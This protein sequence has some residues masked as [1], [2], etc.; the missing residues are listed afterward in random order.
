MYCSA[1]SYSDP[2]I[3]KL[4]PAESEKLYVED[5]IRL[6]R[7]FLASS[8]NRKACLARQSS[9]EATHL[10]VGQNS[11]CSRQA[12]YLAFQGT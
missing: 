7:F 1:T 8:Q 6:R 4:H 9:Q 5:G 12:R 10:A 2:E 11:T 3:V